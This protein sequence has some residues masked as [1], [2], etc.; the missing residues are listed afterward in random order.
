M[1]RVRGRE[2]DPRRAS[3]GHGGVF[4]VNRLSRECDRRGCIRCAGPVVAEYLDSVI[5]HL[6][7]S[8]ASV[9]YGSW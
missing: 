3:S 2:G 1:C 9:D 5:G 6:V 8:D 7:R 4:G